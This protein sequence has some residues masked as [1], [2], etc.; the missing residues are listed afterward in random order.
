MI[1]AARDQ[2]KLRISLRNKNKEE[3]Y[4]RA[5]IEKPLV[6]LFNTIIPSM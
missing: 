6:C 5:N 2:E 1:I 4:I 3:K